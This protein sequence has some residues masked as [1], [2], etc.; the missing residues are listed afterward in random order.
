MTVGVAGPDGVSQHFESY[1]L[2]DFPRA[3]ERFAALAAAP[4]THDPKMLSRSRGTERGATF[5]RGD[6]PTGIAEPLT[7]CL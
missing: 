7:G 1:E 6:G 2:E 5:A 3:T 4:A